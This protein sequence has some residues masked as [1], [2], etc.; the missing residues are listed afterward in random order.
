MHESATLSYVYMYACGEG[1]GETPKKGHSI[2]SVRNN[3][4]YTPCNSPCIRER[5]GG[6]R[7]GNGRKKRRV[8]GK[9][10]GPTIASHLRGSC[11]SRRPGD[12]GARWRNICPGN[13][14]L[15]ARDRPSPIGRQRGARGPALAWQHVRATCDRL[16]G[17]LV[18]RG[19]RVTPCQSETG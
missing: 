12:G 13:D 7:E 8:V 19:P 16:V 6:E 15:T 5:E 4:T 11:T 10:E 2:C 3:I 9:K 17:R 1:G 18:I 14:W